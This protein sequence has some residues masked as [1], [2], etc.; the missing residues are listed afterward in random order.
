[1][2]FSNFKAI[3]IIAFIL[4]INFLSAATS[5][6]TTT[7][8]KCAI[9]SKV[10]SWTTTTVYN[11]KGRPTGMSGVDCDGK[12]W[13]KNL[14][15]VSGGASA[16]STLN[17]WIYNLDGNTLNLAANAVCDYRIINVQTGEW[18][19]DIGTISNINTPL[20]IDITYLNSGVYAVIT[21]SND[22]AI[23]FLQFMK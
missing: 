8:G 9:G 3:T 17:A 16:D 4:T 11:D 7:T 19:S 22:V 21:F 18:V 5:T 1:M 10:A 13:A 12:V 6:T 14:E 23:N 20:P 2:K 15:N